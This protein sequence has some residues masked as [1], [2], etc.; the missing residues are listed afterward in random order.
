MA[1]ASDWSLLLGWLLPCLVPR[2]IVSCRLFPPVLFSPHLS[3]P[4]PLSTLPQTSQP[5]CLIPCCLSHSLVLSSRSCCPP[6]TSVR[7]LLLPP[8]PHPQART[9]RSGARGPWPL[10]ALLLPSLLSPLPVM[11]RVLPLPPPLPT[12]SYRHPTSQLM[13]SPLSPA[14]RLFRLAPLLQRSPSPCPLSHDRPS[15]QSCSSRLQLREQRR[16]LHLHREACLNCEVSKHKLHRVV[17]GRGDAE[18]WAPNRVMWHCHV[19][20]RLSTRALTCKG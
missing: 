18:S 13:L 8:L 4:L 7:S 9:W 19:V 5:P 12:C 2:C 17:N 16:V 3:S 14:T 6:C 20:D 10:L 15:L 1:C 11:A